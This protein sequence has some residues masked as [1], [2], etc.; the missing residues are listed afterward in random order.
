MA[1]EVRLPTREEIATLPQWARVALAVRCAMRAQPLFVLGWPK[2]PR[3][4]VEE[5]ERAIA[6][7]ACLTAGDSSNLGA[8]TRIK[9]RV[10]VADSNP[11]M[12]S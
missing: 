12:L 7:A 11:A 1:G 8:M 3:D 4:H 10:A 2:A 6:A 5:V 9:F